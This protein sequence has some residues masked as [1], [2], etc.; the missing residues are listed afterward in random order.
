MNDPKMTQHEAILA[1]TVQISDKLIKIWK[2]DL[3]GLSFDFESQNVNRDFLN[4]LIHTDFKDLFP[5]KI[6]SSRRK[7]ILIWLIESTSEII[8]IYEKYSHVFKKF[9]R[10]GLRLEKYRHST[11]STLSDYDLRMSLLKK[12]ELYNRKDYF[13]SDLYKNIGF[14]DQDFHQEI[15]LHSKLLL[16]DLKNNLENYEQYDTDKFFVNDKPIFP[17]IIIAKIHEI[18]NGIVYNEILEND[19]YNE[20]NYLH[21]INKI[22]ICKDQKIYFF[23]IIHLL[24][25]TL[26][27]K[28]KEKWLNFI[29]KDFQIPMDYYKSKYRQLASGSSSKNSKIFA[30]DLENIFLEYYK[31]SNN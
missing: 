18:S 22:K 4:L 29:L 25:E 13:E 5:S 1:I 28:M 3:V 19:F 26:D 9:D 23:Y 20:I 16:R 17:M 8:E 24:S 2:K 15:Y 6:E 31:Y 30:T 10:D 14:L 21:S 27:K 11:K 12:I 7:E